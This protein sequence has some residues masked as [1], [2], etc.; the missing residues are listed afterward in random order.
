VDQ[1][2]NH[3]L[4]Y[5]SAEGRFP[6]HPHRVVLGSVAVGHAPPLPELHPAAQHPHNQPL[7]RHY[8]HQSKGEQDGQQ[9]AGELHLSLLSGWLRRVMRG[10]WP[11]EAWEG[12]EA[13]LDEEAQVVALLVDGGGL[14]HSAL[15]VSGAHAGAV[16]QHQAAGRTHLRVLLLGVQHELVEVERLKDVAGESVYHHQ[17]VAV[18]VILNQLLASHQLVSGRLE[19]P[20]EAHP[21]PQHHS[22][23]HVAGQHRH[24]HHFPQLLLTVGSQEDRF[25]QRKALLAHYRWLDHYSLEQDVPDEVG[26]LFLC[27]ELSQ[28]LEAAEGA[29]G[30]EFGG[31]KAG[32]VGV[33]VFVGAGEQFELDD[34]VDQQSLEEGGKGSGQLVA[35]GAVGEEDPADVVGLLG[36]KGVEFTAVGLAVLFGKQDCADGWEILFDDGQRRSI[37]SL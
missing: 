4:V 26:V 8:L 6:P 25:H 1:L 14:E 27:E 16:E 21:R 33:G 11:D 9:P 22:S 10:S 15:V 18:V 13:L 36:K 35:V 5:H 23:R 28:E 34:V 37:A 19:Q 20:L 31:G 7:H 32:W 29:G 30:G 3:Q 24:H 17:Q 12:D 2:G